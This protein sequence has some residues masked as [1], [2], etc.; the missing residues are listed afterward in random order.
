MTAHFITQGPGPSPVS[1]AK[2]TPYPRGPRA[3]PPLRIRLAFSLNF[4]ARAPTL[5][6][7]PHQT[8][9]P[10]E[11]NERIHSSRER[12]HIR[13]RSAEVRCA[14]PGGLLGGM[15]RPLQGDRTR[16]RRSGKGIL[17][18]AQGSEG[19]RRRESGGPEEIRRPRD[20]HA[21]AVQEWQRGGAEGRVSV[22]VAADRVS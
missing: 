4:G 12:R 16:A 17:G 13:A 6:S 21:D 7:G 9:S 11:A 2:I 22:Q 18:K 10:E 19:Q 5:R 3:F 1:P 20:T 8:P 14:G 15:V